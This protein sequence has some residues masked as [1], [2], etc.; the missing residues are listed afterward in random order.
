MS[1]SFLDGLWHASRSHCSL[2]YLCTVVCLV[3]R[4][5]RD[6]HTPRL[7]L[8]IVSPVIACAAHCD[9]LFLFLTSPEFSVLCL[10]LGLSLYCNS[11]ALIS[12]SPLPY[13]LLPKVFTYTLT[14]PSNP[15]GSSNCLHTRTV[16]VTT[17]IGHAW[18]RN[19]NVIKTC[20]L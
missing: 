19:Q 2:F 7:V 16:R 13:H 4:S 15:L 3:F 6:L 11:E 12:S 5:P 10:H 18:I 9:S 1:L 8:C 20:K 14:Q 17:Y